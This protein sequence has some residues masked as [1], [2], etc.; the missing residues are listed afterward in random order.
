MRSTRR[1]FIKT[2]AVGALGTG[3]IS[4]APLNTLSKTKDYT[5]G[6][7]TEKG[8][9]VFDKETQKSMEELAETLLPGAKEVGI[10]NI[11]MDYIAT[12]TG[13]AVFFYAGFKKLDTFARSKYK[14]PFYKVEDKDEKESV[15]KYIS[16]KNKRFFKSFR[17]LIIG[18]YYSQPVVWKRLSYSGPPQP[19]G[20]MDYRLPP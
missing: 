20:F 14:K 7:E 15:I 9:K 3:L 17:Q 13:I 8:I 18:L 1:G 16:I 6:I 11:F 19:R 10:K 5:E 12:N 4:V 2:L